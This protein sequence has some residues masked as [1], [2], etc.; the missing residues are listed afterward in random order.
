M[1]GDGGR[2]EM[3]ATY[4]GRDKTRNRVSIPR[5]NILCFS[6]GNHRGD[7]LD[8]VQ[9]IVPDSVVPFVDVVVIVHSS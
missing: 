9:L 5:R 3:R 1:A 8:I 2:Q 6:I 4:D 7:H